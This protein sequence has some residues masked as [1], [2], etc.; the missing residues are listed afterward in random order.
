MTITTAVELVRYLRHHLAGSE[1]QDVK[2]V[3]DFVRERVSQRLEARMK[4]LQ[5]LLE[6]VPIDYSKHQRLYEL[7]NDFSA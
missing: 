3:E 6:G 5:V 1:W 7:L 4:L 2:A